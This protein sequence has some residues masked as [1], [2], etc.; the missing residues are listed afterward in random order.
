MPALG[1]EA[2]SGRE[3]QL[4][5]RKLSCCAV[6]LIHPARIG[7]LQKWD[8]CKWLGGTPYQENFAVI[9]RTRG[10]LLNVLVGLLNS[11]LLTVA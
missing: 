10:L 3:D 5:K 2:D 9:W 6:I 11:G 8:G 1:D 4:A 7:G